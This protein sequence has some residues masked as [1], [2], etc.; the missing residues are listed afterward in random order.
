M[1]ITLDELATLR[2]ES[3]IPDDARL[4]VTAAELRAL[5][6]LIPAAREVEQTFGTY[7]VPHFEEPSHASD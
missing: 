4:A 2:P 6:D 5:T 1:S 7:E 3:D